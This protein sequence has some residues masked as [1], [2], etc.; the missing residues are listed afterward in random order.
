[1]HAQPLRPTVLDVLR[2]L[3]VDD[4]EDLRGLVTLVLDMSGRYETVAVGTTDEAIT[5]LSAHR[6]DG[7]LLDLSLHDRAG[8]SVLAQMAGTGDRTRVILFTA[9][10]QVDAAI[11][12]EV[13]GIIRK[14]FDPLT[15]ADQVGTLLTDQL[16]H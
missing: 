6:F 2:L 5:A 9:A 1:M 10:V 3:I 16:T 13:A 7:V 11:M 15:L 4:D 14:P 8:E 12:A